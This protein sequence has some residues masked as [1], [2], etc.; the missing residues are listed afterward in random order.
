MRPD[1]LIYLPHDRLR[2]RLNAVFGPGFWRM[3]ALSEPKADQREVIQRWKME[4]RD[5]WSDSTTG[6]ALYYADSKTASYGD[7]CE[8]AKSDAFT[9]LCKSMGVGLQCWNRDYQIG[10]SNAY[11]VQVPMLDGKGMQWRR[12]DRPPLRG[13][14]I[15]DR[16]AGPDYERK[17]DYDDQ[18]KE[19]LKA[20]AAPEQRIDWPE[21]HWNKRRDPVYEGEDE[22]RRV[23]AEDALFGTGF[24]T[25]GRED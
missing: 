7:A 12:R 14:R 16:Q 5:G 18:A 25:D 17:P 15:S 24:A 13:E 1:G 6:H 19:H 21:S 3:V 2:A 10:W 4:T 8:T 9:R 20:I 22:R 11:A 23:E